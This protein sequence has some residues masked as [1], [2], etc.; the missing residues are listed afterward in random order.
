MDRIGSADKPFVIA[1]LLTWL[2]FVLRGQ[3]KHRIKGTGQRSFL[4]A[5]G[6]VWLI[7]K[8]A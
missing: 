1:G 6:Q 4:P 3:L 8:Y 5:S 7:R 2:R